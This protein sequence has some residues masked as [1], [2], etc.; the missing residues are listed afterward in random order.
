MTAPR[1]RTRLLLALL[2]TGAYHGVLVLTRTGLKSAQAAEWL[3]L[4]SAYARAPFDP[5]DDRWYGGV[6]LTD[7]SP[8][9]PQLIGLLSGPLGLEG[10]Y[11]A[12]Q[13][14]AV[15]ALLYGTYRFALL[16][17]AG[18]R[19]AGVATLLTLLGSALT[20]S[21]SVFGQLGAVL[22]AGLAL[23]AAPALLAWVKRGRRR[24]MPGWAAPL[25]AAGAAHSA[26]PLLLLGTLVLTLVV[27]GAARRRS[28][29]AALAVPGTLLLLTALGSLLLPV[30][31]RAAPETLAL[32]GVLLLTPL[33]ALVALR[34]WDAARRGARPPLA[35]LVSATLVILGSV[36]LNALS[37]TRALEGPTLN[38]TPL[39]NFIEKDEHWRYRYLTVGFGTQ[40]GRLSAQ[41]RAA[42]LSGLWHV[43]PNLPQPLAPP[44]AGAAL[45]ERL[46]LPG[47]GRL[48]EVLT[49][50]DRSYLKFVYARSDVLDPLLFMHGWH[51]IGTLENGVV[52]WEREDI[53]P[54]PAR[55]ARPTLPVPLGALW[56]TAPLLAL[57]VSALLLPLSIPAWRT[58]PPLPVEV[59]RPADLFLVPLTLAGAA[60]TLLLAQ[61]YRPGWAAQ[62]YL[63]SVTAQPATTGGLRGPYS[64]LDGARV[65]ITAAGPGRAS[66]TVHERWWTPLGDRRSTR[67]L[68]LTLGARGWQVR[69]G[70]AGP[71][72]LRRP[73]LSPQP[74]VVFYRAPRRI[75]TN[76]TAPAD[77]L[78][79]PVLQVLPGRLTRDARGRVWYLTEVLCA[80]A[81]PADLTVTV[82]L[83]VNGERVAQ[84]NAGLF[85]QHKLR[86]GERSPLRVQLPPLPGVN[87]DELLT[88]GGAA[89]LSVE[90]GARAVVT[91]RHLDRPLVSRSRVRGGRVEVQ[92]RNTSNGTVATPMAL[93]TLFDGRGV[94]W[95]YAVAGPELPPGASWS[96]TLPA[97]PPV[98][99]EVLAVPAPPLTDLATVQP[100]PVPPGAF[101][102]PGGGAYRLSFVTPPAPERPRPVPLPTQGA[103]GRPC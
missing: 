83:R 41:T 28:V 30:P 38:L 99:R 52:V 69:E 98:T 56:G 89:R 23:N 73:T 19:G 97:A 32:L 46:D 53:P 55:L 86:S 8:L 31:W 78:D 57:L 61:A 66:A 22:G 90:V 100:R 88:A 44:G 34:G 26:A 82:I 75:T 3:F 20:L 101:P 103:G 93:L 27:A 65:Q 24:D 91:G 11:A 102:L 18:P 29:L 25:L 81:R 59:A 50:P 84:A 48:T 80:D 71:I 79:R 68:D 96:F 64:R 76:V 63:V 17:G 4:A 74:E 40:L 58:D 70:G 36:S 45:S 16:L 43:P 54:V 95:V 39:L 67:R 49:H 60:L 12:A 94:R 9:L 14:L 15:L 10:A 87:L 2:L 33:S 37:T 13:F 47:L 6:P 72:T 85:A 7:V 62:R 1:R 92:A 42:T 77:V 5:F 51:N 21:V 35:L